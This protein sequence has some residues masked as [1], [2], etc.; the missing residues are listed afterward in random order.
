MQISIKAHHN[1]HKKG[2]VDTQKKCK[3]NGIVVKTRRLIGKQ[4]SLDPEQ[5]RHGIENGN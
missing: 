2:A 5:I 4:D 1:N 3:N